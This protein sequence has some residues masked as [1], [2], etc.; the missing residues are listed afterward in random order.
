MGRSLPG[1]FLLTPAPQ[2]DKLQ[3]LAGSEAG[4]R[5]Q[6]ENFQQ[7]TRL[8]EMMQDTEVRVLPL[9]HGC[10]ARSCA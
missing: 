7:Q 3:A 6:E 4:M 9:H 2:Q 1:F 8:T 5:L 10:P